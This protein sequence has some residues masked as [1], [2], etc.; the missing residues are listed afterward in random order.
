MLE[1]GRA[2]NV[3]HI[4][5]CHL[6]E[7][8]SRDLLG[9]N[10]F[11]SLMA[12]LEEIRS[13]GITPDCILV[14]GDISQDGSVAAYAT[15]KDALSEYN[16]PI[17]WFSGNHDHRDNMSQVVGEGPELEKVLKLGDW[18]LILLDSLSPGNV[19]GELASSELEVL[20]AALEA[21][22]SH[23][24]VCLHHHPV[25]IGSAWLDRIG[26]H[27]PQAFLEIVDAHDQVEG[28]LWGHVH[29]E[30]DEQWKGKR[31][32]APPST[33]IQ[34]KQNSDDFALDEIAPGYRWL[35]LNS[36]GSIDTRV[37]RAHSFEYVLDLKSNGY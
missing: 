28:V 9:M 27:N 14:T 8:R 21:D 37:Q 7:D 19:H 24:L 32:L 3:L 12:V 4:T 29:Q 23:S 20:S 36:D 18:Q 2:V 30:F 25:D 26:L 22:K 6:N 33:C 17:R 10:T 34:F 1:K 31:M 5:D 11:D 16:C 13:E 15:I 35:S